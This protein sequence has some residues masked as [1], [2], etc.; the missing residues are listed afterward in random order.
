[1]AHSV[2]SYPVILSIHG[3]CVEIH[4]ADNSPPY[5]YPSFYVFLPKPM[6]YAIV[7]GWPIVIP[8][9]HAYP[10]YQQC[11][12]LTRLYLSAI[13]GLIICRFV[14]QGHSSRR[15]IKALLTGDLESPEARLRRVGFSDVLDEMI[16]EETLQGPDT[17]ATPDGSRTGSPVPLE[18]DGGQ[19]KTK[20]KTADTS[21]PIF[22]QAQLNAISNLTNKSK[23]PKLEIVLVFLPDSRNA[24]GTMIC[25]SPAFMD[26]VK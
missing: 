11:H 1:M 25:R 6:R 24:H 23:I 2:S 26:H 13:F 7:F 5:F 9:T 15:R 16:E 22:S 19:E 20:L 4:I 8:G 18:I 10:F 21:Q 3:I 14:V 12:M 17:S